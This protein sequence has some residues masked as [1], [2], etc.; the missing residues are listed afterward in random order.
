MYIKE[1][2]LSR[3]HT[4]LHCMVPNVFDPVW[5]RRHPVVPKVILVSKGCQDQGH[6]AQ[7]IDDGHDQDGPKL[8]QEGVGQD[9]TEQGGEVA[10]GIP[11]G[12]L[13]GGLFLIH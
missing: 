6:L 11:E 4:N 12:D 3:N 10:E 13:G 2:Y 7:G 5:R 9:G 1:K 8:A